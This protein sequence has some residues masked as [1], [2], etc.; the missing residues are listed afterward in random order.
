MNSSCFPCYFSVCAPSA[1]DESAEDRDSKGREGLWLAEVPSP[2]LSQ[3]EVAS[4]CIQWRRSDAQGKRGGFFQNKGQWQEELA[5]TT[6]RQ[7]AAELGSLHSPEPQPI[8]GFS[9]IN[10]SGCPLFG[11]QNPMTGLVLFLF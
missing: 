1:L 7:G 6:G 9:A 4:V 3:E 11:S 10:A 2:G 5:L 8:V